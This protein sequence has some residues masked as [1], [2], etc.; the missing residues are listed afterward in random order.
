VTTLRRPTSPVRL[1]GPPSAVA[2][3]AA[4][5]WWATGVAPFT[6]AAY[7]AVGIPVAAVAVGASLGT[8]RNGTVSPTPSPP[9][10][11]FRAALPWAVLGGMALVLELVALA[12]GGR[13][14]AVPTFSTVVDHAL[15]RHPVRFLLFSA[16]LALAGVPLVRRRPGGCTRP[17]P[18]AGAGPGSVA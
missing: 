5:A 16:W 2:A 18:G 8:R 4:Y 17:V 9:T 3:V 6:G 12:L 1:I 7:A 10:G 13:S 11:A 14:H 15:S